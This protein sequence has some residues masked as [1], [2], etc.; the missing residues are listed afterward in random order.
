MKSETKIP[1]FLINRYLLRGNKWKITLI[2]F[3]M[4]IA[5]INLMFVSSLFG[6][7]IEMTNSQ[8]I[9]TYTGN[10]MI[11]PKDGDD[12]IE[13]S[14]DFS[15]KLL[16]T[17]GVL[18]VSSQVVLP[19]SLKY[20]GISGNWTII[21]VNP[22]EEKKVTNVYDK[23]I[24]G[25]YLN[26][27]DLDGIIIG[28][29]IAGG[30]GVEMNAFSF[31]GA[32]VGEKVSLSFDGVSKEYIIRGIFYTKFIDTDQRAFITRKSLDNL[33]PN[34]F[35]DKSNT[36]ILKT[37]ER[38]DEEGV[39]DLIK[40]KGIDASFYTWEDV[41]GLMKTVTESFL[42]IN[43]LLSIVGVLIAAFTIFIVIYIDISSRRKQ[44]GILRA[45]GIK[46][47]LIDSLF[48]MQTVVYSCFGV[49]LGAAI[50]FGIIIPYFNAY[51]FVLPIGDATLVVNYTELIIKTE[52]IIFVAI[53]SGLFPA[54][55]TTRMKLLDAIWG[56]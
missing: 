55:A 14:D 31:R 24:E 10:I 19:A 28:R 36:F 41:A 43:I 53:F 38:G 51:P 16:D 54:I 2:I 20:E 23:I 13:K 26:G 8:I 32:K 40:S 27:D 50:F 15:K 45:I 21:A 12:L 7:I 48:V 42:S 49:L 44:I 4:S 46:P 11:T 35:D 3:L 17:E 47:Y 37:E 29:Q 18:E 39:I 33:V 6:G 25:R 22:E 30:E 56:R 9:D 5:F 34:Y 52:T 1:F